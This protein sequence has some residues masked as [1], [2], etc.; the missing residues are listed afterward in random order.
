MG[1]FLL[2]I[3]LFV[4]ANLSPMQVFAA[5]EEVHG[6]YHKTTGILRIVT[7]ADRCKSWENHVAL[8]KTGERG[9]AG[10]PGKPGPP[11]QM[12]PR[13]MP[14]PEG[15]QGPQGPPGPPGTSE[16]AGAQGSPG[17]SGAH[18]QPTPGA[19]KASPQAN[20]DQA[21][22]FRGSPLWLFVLITAIASSVLSIAAVCLLLI[23]YRMLREAAAQSAAS[24]RAIGVSSERLENLNDRI[25]VRLFQVMK[26]ILLDR[27]SGEARGSR[28]E[29][30]PSRP[31]GDFRED[32][33]TAVIEIIR[34]PATT[35]L[36]DLQYILR[37]RF[38]DRMIEETLSRL[39]KDGALT[40]E[41][42]EAVPAF[43]TPI[44][45]V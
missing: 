9:P 45:L 38:D 15:A 28:K 32:A 18:E 43:T 44:T 7:D 26:E 3:A 36:R 2:A 27:M 40:W 1:V 21:P 17:F 13:G 29:E 10:E 19:L 35:T 20:A 42:E 8:G 31:S 23:L 14:G 11:G 24:S 6:C 12:G 39:R 37:D 30:A 16:P 25:T 34:R 5:E 33:E 22:P 4:A 41:G